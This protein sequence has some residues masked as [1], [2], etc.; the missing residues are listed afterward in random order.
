MMNCMVTGDGGVMP[1]SK[2]LRFVD[3]EHIWSW[4]KWGKR[5]SCWHSVK[6]LCG[7]QR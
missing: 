6:L 4:W 5:V 3:E 1:M 2:K 7:M